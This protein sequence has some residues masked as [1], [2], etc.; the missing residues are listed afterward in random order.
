MNLEVLN[1]VRVRQHRRRVEGGTT[2]VVKH[3]RNQGKIAVKS[4]WVNRGEGPS[5]LCNKPQTFY[6]FKE[7]NA[8]L[9][10]NSYSAPKGGAYDKHD[11]KVTW[12]DGQTY[13]GRYDVHYNEDA[14]IG[15]HIKDFLEYEI[16]EDTEITPKER[17]EMIR[18][19]RKYQLG[20]VSQPDISKD[21]KFVG[22]TH[23]ELK[24]SNKAIVT[25]RM[26]LY[27][28][29]KGPRV[30]DYIILKD[31][32]LDRFTHNWGN[33]IQVGGMGGSFY[34]GNGFIEYSGGLDPSISKS[35]IVPTKQKRSGSVWIFDDDRHVAGGA[36]YFKVYFRVFKQK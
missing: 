17:E 33:E 34:L 16:K 3:E 30:G 35:E 12:T 14:N 13:N 21:L 10:Q 29:I 2:N 1:M 32:T 9:R 26:R 28:Q 15:K 4:I 18:F 6:T 5:E 23:P 7:A 24:S 25:K 11:F 31:G 22:A 27:D 20:D 19:L 8:F 36:V